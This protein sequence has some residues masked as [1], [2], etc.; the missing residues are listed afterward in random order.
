M[1]FCWSPPARRKISSSMMSDLLIRLADLSITNSK[2]SQQRETAKEKQAVA[3]LYTSQPEGDTQTPTSQS[4]TSP[5]TQ[6]RFPTSYET[7]Q[8]NKRKFSDTS[9]RRRSAETIPQ[10]LIQAEAKV[11]ALQDTFVVT[12]IN[13]VWQGLIDMPWIRGRRM[14]LR[15]TEFLA[16]SFMCK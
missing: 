12:L 10:K 8:N 16:F 1:D 3:V 11:Q 2:E 9:F 4:K 13:K 6:S 14:H 5:W 7:P 15:Y